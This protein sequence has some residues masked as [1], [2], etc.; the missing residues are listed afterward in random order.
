MPPDDPD[1]DQLLAEAVAQNGV[2]T[3]QLFARFGP[4]LRRMVAVN[5]DQRVSAR[6]DPSDIVQEAFAEAFQRLPDY[7]RTRPISFYPWLRQIAWQRLLKLHRAHIAARRRSV[8]REDVTMRLPDDSVSELAKRLVASGT[9]PERKLLQQEIR[10]RVRMALDELQ[11]KDRSLLIMRY[12]EHMN[13]KEISE[14][15][16]VTPAAA[17]MRHARALLRLEQYLAD[18]K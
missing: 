14:V 8:Q 12:L 4:R 15:L 13:L 17:Q 18:L 3:Q 16:K 6:V 2:A 1:T 10:K 9:N 7:I 5:L 11:S